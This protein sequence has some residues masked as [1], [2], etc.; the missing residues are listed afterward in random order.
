MQ[1][2]DKAHDEPGGQERPL[3]LVPSPHSHGVSQYD[4]VVE[5]GTSAVA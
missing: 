4:R 3:V 5:K 2:N 1:Q